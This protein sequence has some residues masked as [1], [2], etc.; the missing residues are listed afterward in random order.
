MDDQVTETNTSRPGSPVEPQNDQT[1]PR[2]QQPVYRF[3]WDPSLRRPGPGSVSEVTDNR[4]DAYGSSNVGAYRFGN[5]SSFSLAVPHEW[6]SSKHGFNG[7]ES[8]G[9]V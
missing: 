5:L 8:G 3:T 4:Y 1:T 2:Q 9:T 7:T 6:S